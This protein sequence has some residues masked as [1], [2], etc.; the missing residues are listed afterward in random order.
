MSTLKSIT[1]FFIAAQLLAVNIGFAQNNNE[2]VVLTAGYQFTQGSYNQGTDTTIQYIPVSALYS[3]DNWRYELTVPYLIITGNGNVIPGTNGSMF[4][5]SSNNGGSGMNNGFM[6]NNNQTSNST[7]TNSGLGDIYARAAYSFN[8]N[9]NSSLY[10]ELEVNSKF[11]TASTEKALGTGQ[12]DYAIQLNS[13][14]VTNNVAYLNVGYKVVGDSATIDYNNVIYGST[15][16]SFTVDNT[17]RLGFAFDYQQ[18]TLDNFDDFQQVSVSLSWV[19]DKKW[20]IS[21]AALAGLTNSSPDFGG[22]IYISNN[23]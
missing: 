17:K 18:T 22:S 6:N 3:K 8:K 1:P 16:I 7:I 4:T 19:Q 15:G 10:Y 9:S 12:N 21:L 20:S 11:G 14:Y 23:Y 5:G 13:S 2:R